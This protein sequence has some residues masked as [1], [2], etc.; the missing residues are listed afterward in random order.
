[1]FVKNRDFT[2]TLNVA[3]SAIK[4]HKNFVRFNGGQD[5]TWLNYTF[6]LP[7]DTNNN[8]MCPVLNYLS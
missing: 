6:N 5:E 3:K 7:E 2:Q 4:N 8:I 1:M